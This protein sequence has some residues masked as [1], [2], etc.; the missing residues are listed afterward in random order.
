MRE[1][2]QE[3]R[4]AGI[5]VADVLRVAG[6]SRASFYFYFPSRQALLGELVRQAVSQGHDA[7][8]PFTAQQDDRV[9]ALRSGIASGAALWRRNAGVLRAIVESWGSDDD[10]RQLWL[11]QMGT[12]TDA[13]VAVIQADPVA[14]RYLADTDVRAVAA[15]LTW[16]G[17]RL[18]YLA[19]AGVPPF[20]DQALL[21][22][23]LLHAWTSTLYG[24][25]PDEPPPQGPDERCVPKDV[26]I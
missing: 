9:E 17:E 15:T 11:Q 13:A 2:L 1:L 25:P 3:Q 24:M 22:D 23:T 8:R 18:Y 20:D 21:V 26:P 10:L 6:V 14:L 7:A 5:S 12:F 4:F 19:A 16:L